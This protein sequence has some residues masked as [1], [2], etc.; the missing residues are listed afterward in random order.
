HRG[1]APLDLTPAPGA[2]PPAGAE[3]LPT[4]SWRMAA[5]TRVTDLP[6]FAEGRFWV[7]DAAAALPAM[8]L[9]PRAG[10]RIA[11]L[12]AAPGGKT[13]Q[14]LA[15]GAV[16]TAVER[17]PS[18][19]ARLRENLARLHLSAEVVQADAATWAPAEPFDAI[20][21]DA[22]CTATGTIRRHP[23]VAHAKRPRD[24]ASAA[25]AQCRLLAAAA[26][27]LRPGGRLV[28]ATCS[29]QPEEGE[30][31]LARAAG[32]GLAHEPFAPAELPG[33]PE[34][35]TPAGCLRTRPDLWAERGGMDGFFAVRFR[36]AA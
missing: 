3:V 14:L 32:L 5:G 7:Q 2:S 36:R 17:D 6:G 15:A 26:R 29:L 28:F 23:D 30:A 19:A 34:A 21:L 31:H 16:V 12:C 4:G 8:L 13:A 25:E 24:V 1:P 10:E 27:M 22:P 35:I 20:L 33:L 18:R 9:A 11:D